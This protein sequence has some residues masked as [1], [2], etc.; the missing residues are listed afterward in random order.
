LLVDVVADVNVGVDFVHHFIHT[1]TYSAWSFN[2]PPLRSRDW[3]NVGREG[4]R[5]S[6]GH[7]A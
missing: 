4:V 1:V 3:R 6:A 7:A 5:S 2:V